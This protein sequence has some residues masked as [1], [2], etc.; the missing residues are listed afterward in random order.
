MCRPDHPERVRRAFGAPGLAKVWAHTLLAPL[1]FPAGIQ[2]I[3]MAPASSPVPGPRCAAPPRLAGGLVKSTRLGGSP[4]AGAPLGS[5]P[6]RSPRSRRRELLGLVPAS[7][8]P[9]AGKGPSSAALGARHHHHPRGRTA[10]AGAS[11]CGLASLPFLFYFL[12]YSLKIKSLIH[13]YGQ[14]T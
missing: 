4:P 6:P 1:L 7:R 5:S 2:T 14:L 12:F 11:G 13:A 3:R 8:P 10:C 9:P